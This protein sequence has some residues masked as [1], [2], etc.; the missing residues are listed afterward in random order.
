M[1]YGYIRVAN[2]ESKNFVS[3]E[4]QKTQIHDMY[5][6]AVLIPASL[7]EIIERMEYQDIL[8]CTTLDR[9]CSNI[10]YGIQQINTILNK[11][12]CIHILNMG[13]I[14]NTE[15][16]QL[17][18]QQLLAFALY[19]KQISSERSYKGKVK[20]KQNPKFRDGRK[21]KYT[22]KQ[23]DRAYALLEEKSFRQVEQITG[24][25][26]STLWR[27]KAKKDAES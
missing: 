12:C 10:N 27:Y 19:Q 25:S 6:E 26:Y 15:T 11:G 18:L 20:A 24:I 21:P 14:D 3:F 2:F 16:G 23:L 17:I 9:F 7:D 1:Q 22:K 13:L 5:P 4:E 8:I